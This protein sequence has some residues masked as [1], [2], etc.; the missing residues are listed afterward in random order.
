MSRV[1]RNKLN[2]INKAIHITRIPNSK[3]KSTMQLNGLMRRAAALTLPYGRNTLNKTQIN[4]NRNSR[5][6]KP[7]SQMIEFMWINLQVMKVF[8]LVMQT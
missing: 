8:L 2:R 1:K 3:S 4:C 6:L 5:K 7:V